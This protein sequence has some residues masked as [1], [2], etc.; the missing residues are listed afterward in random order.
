MSW[1]H[2]GDDELIRDVVDVLRG[3]EM[4]QR[5]MEAGNAIGAWYTADADRVLAALLCDSYLDGAPTV[6]GPAPGAPRNLVFALRELRVEVELSDTGVEGQLTLP[7]PGEVWLLDATGPIA[8]TRADEVGCF[9]F[10]AGRHGPFRIECSV[11]GGRRLATEWI[12]V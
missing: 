1:Q 7:E 9:T 4:E 5:I 12:I 3:D 10:P 2:R 8:E 11:G 6:D